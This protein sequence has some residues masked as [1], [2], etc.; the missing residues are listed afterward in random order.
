MAM[1]KILYAL[2]ALA[3]L[4]LLPAADADKIQERIE[5]LQERIEFFEAKI[6]RNPDSEKVAKWG[7][8]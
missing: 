1:N 8:G 3:I 6:D 5:R 7:P 2:P 4:G